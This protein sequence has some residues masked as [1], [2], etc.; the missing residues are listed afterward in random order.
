MR[1]DTIRIPPVGRELVPK[2]APVL[3]NMDISL[4]EDLLHLVTTL[5]NY[6]A[7]FFLSIGTKYSPFSGHLTMNDR[8]A[9]ASS[10]RISSTGQGNF[11]V[12]VCKLNMAALLDEAHKIEH[13][14]SEYSLFFSAVLGHGNDTVKS[15]LSTLVPPV[16]PDSKSEGDT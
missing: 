6:G 11:D 7:V 9:L 16:V 3:S 15:K 12:Q 5:I 2:L 14:F 4:T 8:I 10:L 13:P 1:F